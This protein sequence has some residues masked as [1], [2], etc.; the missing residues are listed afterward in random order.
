MGKELYKYRRELSIGMGIVLMCV[1]ACL[2]IS[3][4]LKSNDPMKYLVITLLLINCILLGLSIPAILKDVL[5]FLWIEMIWLFPVQI[6]LIS[7]TLV[8][9]KFWIEIYVAPIMIC[10][11]AHSIF[12]SHIICTCVIDKNRY[13]YDPDSVRAYP[14]HLSQ[15][16]HL[17]ARLASYV[18]PSPYPGDGSNSN[19]L[20]TMDQDGKNKSFYT[21]PAPSAPSA[22]Y[23]T[24]PLQPHTTNNIHESSSGLNDAT[25]YVPD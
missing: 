11:T 18:P 17:E 8:S 13:K 10:F 3:Y 6:G 24:T 7:Y 4:I 15:N 16:V 14:E 23:D 9:Y 19:K 22:P 5:W 21:P 1:Y 25:M 2:A 20:A 12:I